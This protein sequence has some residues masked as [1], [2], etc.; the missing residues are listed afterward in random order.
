MERIVRDQIVQHMEDHDLFSKHQH[1]FRKGYSCVT[2]LIEVLEQ[3][4]EAID[5]AET[6]DVIFLDFKKSFLT[7]YHT[8]G[9]YENY[10]DTK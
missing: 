8:R 4:T 5:Q 3:W 7:Q 1:G 2:Q 9:Y 6:V 10:K